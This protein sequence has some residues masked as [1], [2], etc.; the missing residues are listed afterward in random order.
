LFVCLVGWF[1]LIFVLFSLCLV[2]T[3]AQIVGL[4]AGVIAAI[5]IAIV[6]ILAITAGKHLPFP[7]LSRHAFL[8]SIWEEHIE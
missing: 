4:S 5:V 2:L 6:V 1:K 8:I 7:P 3:P